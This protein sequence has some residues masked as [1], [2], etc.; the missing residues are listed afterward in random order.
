MTLGDGF[1]S[2]LVSAQAG[3]EDALAALWRDLNPAVVRYLRVIARTEAEDLAS[4]TWISVAQGLRRFEGDEDGFRRWVFTIARRRWTDWLRST[5][6]RPRADRY[7]AVPELAGSD[8]PAEE[9]VRAASLARALALVHRLP[10]SQAEAVALRVLG[11]FDVAEVAEIMGKQAG[12]VRVLVHRGLK[13]LASEL[14][15]VEEVTP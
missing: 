11:G 4:A 9:A 15:P 8:D 12:A 14:S 2:V 10:P 13:R 5:S 6:R 1:D 3:D 7:A